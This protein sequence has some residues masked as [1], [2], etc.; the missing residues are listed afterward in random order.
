MSSPLR[1]DLRRPRALDAALLA[2]AALAAYALWLSAA[3][4]LALLLVPLLLA[5][6]WPRRRAMRWPSVVLRD[7]GTAA[8][9]APDGTGIEVAA[10]RLR[11]RGPLTLLTLEAEGR[12]HLHLFTPDT[13]PRADAR[14]LRLWFSRHRPD[15]GA[16]AVPHV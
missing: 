11:R 10:A 2:L 1:L 6:A 16:A 12:M 8:A 7:D 9:L 3:P 15:D 4:R 13:L 5:A 14:R